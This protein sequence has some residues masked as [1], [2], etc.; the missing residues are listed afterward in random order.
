MRT[1]ATYVGHRP[2]FTAIRHEFR[3]EDGPVGRMLD[4]DTRLVM[5]RARTLVGVRSGLL[6]STIGREPM[7]QGALGPYRDVTAGKHGLTNYLGYH[8]DPTSPHI[9][10]PNRRKRLR[11]VDR[12][13]R[14]VFARVV[15][16]PGTRGTYFLTRAL[17]VLR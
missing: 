16:H 1:R 10:R 11:F 4:D 7:R 14:V 2:D 5:N 17:E 12:T 9:I 13:G 6:L 15:H 3:G 8:H